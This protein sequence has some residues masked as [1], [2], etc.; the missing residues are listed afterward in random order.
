MIWAMKA[1]M[2]SFT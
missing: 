1:S 2:S